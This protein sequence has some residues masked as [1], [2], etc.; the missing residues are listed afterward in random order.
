MDWQNLLFSF[1]GRIRRSHYWLAGIGSGFAI[2]VVAAIIL[3][4]TGASGAMMGRGGGPMASVGML[5]YFA[6]IALAVYIGL[7]LQVKRWH[8]RDKGW[9]WVLIN[10]IPFIGGLWALI[11]CGFMDGTQGPNKYGPSP[12]GIGG[13]ATA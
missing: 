13:P 8:D 1:N 3:T 5:I 11:E 4:V 10:L 2:G 7:A 9:I 12:K 6:L